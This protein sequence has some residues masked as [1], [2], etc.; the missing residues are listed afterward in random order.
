MW[1]VAYLIIFLIRIL[2]VVRLKQKYKKLKNMNDN[3]Y[4]IL[5]V[6]FE[7]YC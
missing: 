7:N 6:T 5:L 1:L 4:F 3:I 2:I